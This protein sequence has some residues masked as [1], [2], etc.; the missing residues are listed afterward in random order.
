MKNTIQRLKNMRQISFVHVLMSIICCPSVL[1][2]QNGVTVL[3][4]MVDAGTVTFNVSWN[5]TTMP[6]SLWSDSVWVFVDYNNAGKMERLPLLPG[7]TLTATS[8]PD[9]GRIIQYS[10]NNKGV[11]VVGNARNAGSFS[12]TVKLLTVTADIAGACAYASNYPPVGEYKTTTQLAFTGTPPYEI[13]LKHEG[14]TTI[15][16]SLNSGNYFVPAS[17]TMQSFSDKTGSPGIIKCMPM[18]GSINFTWM[19]VNV[20]KGQPTTFTVNAVPTTPPTSA[21]TYSWSAPGFN[22]ATHTGGTFNTTAP[23]TPNVYEVT[24]TTRSF[25]YC[26]LKRTNSITVADCI[27]PATFTLLASASGYCE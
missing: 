6:V 8:A 23:A 18:T 17:Y 24:L 2:A 14:G 4:L 16:Q 26:D 15:T 7:A 27:T 12:A 21:V 19:P 13:V 3:G 9:V 22:P 11:W 1:T 20:P 10:D 5:K 25:G